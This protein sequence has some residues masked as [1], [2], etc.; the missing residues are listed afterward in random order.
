MTNRLRTSCALAVKREHENFVLINLIVRDSILTAYNKAY[1]RRSEYLA[2]ASP[3]CG[4]R[5]PQ[6]QVSKTLCDKLSRPLIKC[7]AKFAKLSF[8][9]HVQ[10]NFFWVSQDMKNF[11]VIH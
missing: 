9:V 1:L 2:W 11:P 5:P 8:V 7:A 4:K 6:R 3:H 10:K